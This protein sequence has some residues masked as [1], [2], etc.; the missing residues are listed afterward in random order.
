MS[1]SEFNISGSYYN[2]G[3]AVGVQ[4]TDIIHDTFDNHKGLHQEL[5]VYNRTAAGR[6][7]YRNLIALHEKEYPQFMQ[8]LKGIA[9][10]AGRHFEE[11]F[12]MNLRGEYAGYTRA[13]ALKGCSTFSVI[14]ETTAVFAHNE[15]GLEIFDG[16]LFLLTAQPEGKPKFSALTYPGFIS[17][18]SLG[19]NDEG[20]CFSVNN[21]HPEYITE[22]VGRHFIARSIFEATTVE[23]AVAKVTRSGRAAGFNYTIAS[24]KERRIVNVEVSTEFHHIREIESAYCHTNHFVELQEVAQTINPTSAA[25]LKRGHEYIHCG[26]F[27]GKDDVIAFI[28]DTQNPLYPVYRDCTPPDDRVTLMTAVFDLDRATCTLYKQA[29]KDGAEALVR[30]I[31]QA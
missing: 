20:I 27:L 15:D 29:P 3:F 16:R 19:F 18:N 9:D 6:Q 25:R 7:R 8:E 22:G 10:G 5:L 21:V 28:A 12:L 1:I 24:V 14:N 13:S 17:G 26:R 31:G 30:A 4:F 23:E 11:L 2:I